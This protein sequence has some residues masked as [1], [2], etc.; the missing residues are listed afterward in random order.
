MTTN[1][2]FRGDAVKKVWLN[3]YPADVPAEINPDRYQ[4][5]VELFEHATTRYADQPAFINM[6]E[7]M[8]YRK[9]EERSR[10][11]AAY[12]QEGLGLQKGDRVALMMPNL[13]QYPVALFGILRAG[14]IV[15]NVNPL[16]T[17]R[18][19]E[20]QLNDSGAA[21]IVIV[22]NF[23]HT[24]EKVVA[25]TQVQHVILTR[26]GDQLS[27]AKG[28]LVNFVV[29]YIKRLVPKYHLPDAI[30]F[31]SA[32][33]HGY[34]MQY[35]KPEIVAEDLAFL[36]Y[37]GGTTG[38]AKGAMLTHRNM[39]ANLEQVNATYGPLLHRGK[40]FVV[41]ALP[42][43]HIFALTMNC[44]LFIELGGQNLLITNPRDIPGVQPAV[45]DNLIRRVRA[46]PVA[47]HHLRPFNTELARLTRC[48]FVI[49]I[50][51][52][53]GFGG[54]HR[55]ANAAAVV[56][57]IVRVNA[58][59]RGTLCQAVALQQILPGQFYPALGHRLLH[60]HPTAGGQMQRGEIKLLELF[61]VQQGV[62]QGID[63]GHGGKRIL[64]Q[65]LHQPGDIAVM[66][67]E[68]F[69]RIV[70]RKKD[71]ILVSGFNV[72]PNEI[73]DVVMQHSGVLEV[74]AIGVPSG[75]S[76]EAVKIF[77]VKKDA[78]LTEEALITFCRRHLT[79]YK[80]PKLVEFRDE[81]PK[82]NVGKILRRELRDEARAKVDNKG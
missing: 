64:R 47:Q 20:H 13:L 22:S 36:Q 74:A 77:V 16:Y 27:T 65:L 69:L 34:R 56:V 14:M 81:L 60:R 54:G 70:D 75:S 37:T 61:V 25:K 55:Q 43:Y 46:L 3:R 63:P 28:T 49:I 30:S 12:L 7:V 32:L 41:T 79:G 8:T 71:M 23:A 11:F 78:A 48:H 29:K 2:Y 52:Q 40:E 10:A 82:S 24:L 68:G 42:L 4:S 45:F 53:F 5:L 18:E 51:H 33:Q 15:V 80:V 76:G 57:N 59:Q 35:V 58:D 21:A 66:D 26:M 19:L 73:E 67:E 39:L 9:L 17:P 72:Y 62:E 38:V 1:N 50:I 31:R 44:L 6:G